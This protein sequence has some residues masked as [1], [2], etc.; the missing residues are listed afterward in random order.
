MSQIKIAKVL[1]RLVGR[2]GSILLT[3]WKRLRRRGKEIV[4]LEG[5]EAVVAGKYM[6]V[7]DDTWVWKGSSSGM[8]SV[9]SLRGLMAL[10]QV[11]IGSIAD[12]N[13]VSWVPIKLIDSFGGYFVTR[14]RLLII[15]CLEG[16]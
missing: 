16:M 7:S 4:E 8:F 5:L 10:S 11:A 13:W 9:S 15:Y 12:F 1:G 2:D 3:D 14:S 6:S